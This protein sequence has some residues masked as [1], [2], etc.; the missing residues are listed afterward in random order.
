M[1]TAE[2]TAQ[3]FKGKSFRTAR[4]QVSRSG[5]SSNQPLPTPPV[6][7]PETRSHLR[8]DDIVEL[9]VRDLDT[10]ISGH[11]EESLQRLRINWSEA[12]LPEVNTTLQEQRDELRA[13]NAQLAARVAAVENQVSGVQSNVSGLRVEMYDAIERN[14]NVLR[15]VRTLLEGSRQ[16]A[17]YAQPPGYIQP[18]GLLQHQ[19]QFIAPLQQISPL[20][21]G[22]MLGLPYTTPGP[23][24]ALFG[25]R[26]TR[27]AE[28][29][30]MQEFGQREAPT[31]AGDPS[32][33]TTNREVSA[34]LAIAGA[35]GQPSSGSAV[36]PLPSGPEV[37]PAPSAAG[38]SSSSG[39]TAVVP[40]GS[41]LADEPAPQ[42][43]N[44]SV[45]SS[46]H[47]LEPPPLPSPAPNTPAPS[48]PAPPS[49]APP[50]PPPLSPAPPSPAPTDPGAAPP[51]GPTSAQRGSVPPRQ[52]TPG[53]QVAVLPPTSPQTHR[54]MS[55]V[56]TQDSSHDEE[57]D[58]DQVKE[59]ESQLGD[60]DN[61]VRVSFHSL[62]SS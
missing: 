26:L 52:P 21:T 27:E 44:K 9:T 3:S 33:S 15:T 54:S 61:M 37:D 58:I 7:T 34:P 60:E 22:P 42:E 23:F 56:S 25:Q 39:P 43:E 38:A 50:S 57:N 6:L 1:D 2:P 13:E 12:I 11:V 48:S 5:S 30:M 55:P 29:D 19:P 45:A 20:N 18:A 53:P 28:M 31:V 17:G 8:P 16:A 32:P 59:Q 49:P 14:T 24:P 4:S 46:P 41:R 62:C 40:A 10:Y 51:A 47:I 35:E 36:P